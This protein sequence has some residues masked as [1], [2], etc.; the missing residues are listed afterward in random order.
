MDHRNSWFSHSPYISSPFVWMKPC[1]HEKTALFGVF[2]ACCA[3][4]PA[5]THS[6]FKRIFPAG[7]GP[8]GVFRMGLVPK[9]CE[10]MRLPYGKWPFS[11]AMLNYQRVQ[12]AS[13]HFNDQWDRF[14]VDG[15][16][17]LHQLKTVVNIPLFIAGW[18]FQPT[19]LKNGARKCWDDYSIPNCETGKSNQFPWF[20]SPPTSYDIPFIMVIYI[21][22]PIKFH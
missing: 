5:A 22:I 2:N 9:C 3:V 15:C 21:Y 13:S 11:I 4:S 12:E 18:G 8:H 20:Q 17:I 19:P 6:I 10:V 14:F 16:D 1:N 7:G